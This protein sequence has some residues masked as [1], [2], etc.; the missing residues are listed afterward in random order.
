MTIERI[1]TRSAIGLGLF[2]LASDL[3]QVACAEDRGLVVSQ[4]ALAGA[5]AADIASSWGKWEANPVLGHGAFQGRQ[6]AIKA[7]IIGGTLVFE[8]I[9]ARKHP[10]YAKVFRWV[11]VGAA[12]GTGAVAIVNWR[13]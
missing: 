9:L 6:V 3:T 7:G 8:T 1:V 2:L 12:A 5:S 11:N 13:K 10:R 4:V